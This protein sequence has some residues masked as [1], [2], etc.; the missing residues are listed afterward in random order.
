MPKIREKLTASP[1]NDEKLQTLFGS[2]TRVKLL[3]LLLSHPENSYYVR[4]LT[5]ILDLQ[6]N[7]IRR[8]L[9]NLLNIGIIVLNENKNLEK[10]I[11][12]LKSGKVVQKGITGIERKYYK[13]NKDFMLYNEL[14]NFF[15]KLKGLT[16]ETFVHRVK[17]CGDI[18]LLILTGIFIKEEESDIDML[19][20]GEIDRDELQKIINDFNETLPREINYTVL[21]TDEFVYRKEVVDKFLYNILQNKNNIVLIDKLTKK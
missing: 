18:S 17:D 2:K 4:E 11:H 6:I 20:V 12:D 21:N 13:L 14:K 10:D 9:S 15:A 3:K 5:R 8:E 7:A 19:M 16:Q 1:F